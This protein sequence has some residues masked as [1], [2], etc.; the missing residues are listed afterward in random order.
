MESVLPGTPLDGVEVAAEQA[1][2]PTSPLYPAPLF[3]CVPANVTNS[4]AQN[5]A[6]RNVN[7]SSNEK[8]EGEKS[9]EE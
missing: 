2:D 9:G 8:V 6:L 3:Y 5:L 1:S 7:L 4:D